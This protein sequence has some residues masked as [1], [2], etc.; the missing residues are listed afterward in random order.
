MN[1]STPLR[2]NSDA[3]PSPLHSPSCQ[4]DEAT[5][6]TSRGRSIGSIIAL[7]ESTFDS[8]A[9]DVSYAGLDVSGSD[10]VD[11]GSKRTRLKDTSRE[12]ASDSPQFWED[13][14]VVDYLDR[15]LGPPDQSTPE[16]RVATL[17]EILA[18]RT[19]IHEGAGDLSDFL[20]HVARTKHG[21]IY[22]R[23]IRT[24]LLNR[25]KYWFKLRQISI[26]CV[27]RY[28]TYLLLLK[29]YCVFEAIWICFYIQRIFSNCLI[30]LNCF[31]SNYL[32]IIFKEG[33]LD[34]NMIFYSA[35]FAVDIFKLKT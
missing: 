2:V 21:K 29:D 8:L 5:P 32:S 14:G 7:G 3:S 25:G 17:R 24:L 11:S 4:R 30:I 26:N 23:V 1:S 20:F 34:T 15:K 19:D 12:N 9:L 10:F 6:S 18:E 27:L 13:I 35:I 22:I 16:E 28:A 31:V 33:M